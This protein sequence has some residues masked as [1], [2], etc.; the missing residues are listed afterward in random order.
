MRKLKVQHLVNLYDL[1]VER[2]LID[3][4][5]DFSGSPVI[6]SLQKPPDDRSSDGCFYKKWSDGINHYCIHYLS[7]GVWKQVNLAATRENYSHVQP[8]GS[9]RWL[10]VQGRANQYSDSNAHIY[11]YTGERLHSFHAGEAISDVQVTQKGH[12]WISFFDQAYGGECLGAD[13]GLVCLDENGEVIFQNRALDIFDCYA[14]NVA[15]ASDTWVYYYTN[16]PLVQISKFQIQR[17][18]DGIPVHGSH[19]FAVNLEYHALFDGNYGDY[20]LFAGSYHKRDSLFLVKLD[21]LDFEELIPVDES[22]KA[23]ISFQAFGRGA[24]L[25]IYTKDV[26]SV[27][28]LDMN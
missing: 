22:G 8:I 16:F 10:I 7:K 3:L 25:F 11:S 28:Q 12:V 27:V 18:W 4:S 17:R 9:D 15:S 14:M 2:H 6:L 19:A 24:K 21:T 20:A 26:L 13:S 5:V 1:L 23:I